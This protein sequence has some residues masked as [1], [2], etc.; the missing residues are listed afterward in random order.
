MSIS[1][2]EKNAVMPEHPNFSPENHNDDMAKSYKEASRK[3][4]YDD[5]RELV[6]REGKSIETFLEELGYNGTNARTVRRIIN[7]ETK[8]PG[9][10]YTIELV[11]RIR[12]KYSLPTY[13]F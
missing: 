8:D 4:V 2:Q 12:G 1:A 6:A 13:L 7:G 9:L 3:V 11:R 5:I 10:D